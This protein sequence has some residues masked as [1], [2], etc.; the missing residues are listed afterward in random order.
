MG[1]VTGIGGGILRDVMAMEMPKVLHKRVYAV[2]SILGGVLYW[3]L[4]RIEVPL[5]LSWAIAMALIIGIRMLA[6]AFH[7]NMPHVDIPEQV[8]KKEEKELLRK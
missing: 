8:H 5:V 2:A 6:T 3:G 1:T 7:W 4:L